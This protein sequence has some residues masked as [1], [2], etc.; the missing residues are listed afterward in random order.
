MQN[1]LMMLCSLE[2][3]A[4]EVIL[5]Q[6]CPEAEEDF[7]YHWRKMTGKD[8]VLKVEKHP[9]TVTKKTFFQE[10]FRL[11]SEKGKVYISGEGPAGISHGLYEVL[12]R[13]GCDWIVPGELGEVIPK[14]DKPDLGE[15]DFEQAPSFDY[16]NPWYPGSRRAVN[17]KY[18]ADYNL[19]KQRHKLSRPG[20]VHPLRN[21]G[22]H[23]WQEFIRAYQKEFDENPEMYALVRQLD[24]T[25]VRKGP[26]IETTSAK[27]LD[28]YEKHIREMFRKNNWPADK[29]VGIGVG[30][31]DGGGAS[32]S[33]ETVSAASGQLNPLS[34]SPELIDIMILFCNQLLA[35]LEKDYPNLHLGFYLYS[36]HADYPVR[37]PIHPKIVIV[38][39]DI[40]Y[41][42]MHSSQEKVPS[43]IYYRKIMEKWANTPNIKF[44]RGYNWNLAEN[45][46]PYS[47][48]KIWE[49]DL[50]LYHR[51]GIRGV[52][53]ESNNGWGTLAPSNYF[54]AKMLWDVTLKAAPVLHR[55]CVSAF[56]KA[57]APMEKY[58][59]M[60]TDRQSKAKQE[61]GSFHSFG[62]IYDNAFLDEA[63]KLFDEA[64]S[65]A[66][67]EV[68]RRRIDMFYIPVRQLRLF[69][70]LRAKMHAFRFDE[71]EKLFFRIQQERKDMMQQIPYSVSAAAISY[72][73]RFFKNPVTTSAK[74]SRA[75]YK[76]EFKVP[77]RLPFAFDP[78]NRGEDLGFADPEVDDSG[79][80]TMRTYSST[81]AAQG[82]I[83]LSGSTWYRVRVPRIEGNAGLLIGGADKQV[84]VY[85]NGKFI[86]EDVGFSKAMLFDLTGHLDGE[87]NLL[88]IQVRRRG[89]SELGTGGLIY[90]CYI[91][92]GPRLT[93]EDTTPGEQYR[94]LPGGAVE[95]VRK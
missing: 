94:L 79:W 89:S 3:G 68:Q 57:A 87:N 90:P 50:P 83:G 59:L 73:D 58:Y 77:D 43:R 64:R 9:Y 52:D 13:L 47:K 2:L 12:Q 29:L 14:V 95:K 75:P 5:D 70:E 69:L 37:Y 19:W 53:N 20:A 46:L 91:F 86:G 22:G 60:L 74:Y 45:I 93:R 51:M 40:G 15:L 92:T 72:F 39:A 78:T 56:G 76:I 82:L 42:R 62:L 4:F 23:K 33:P 61:A 48:L 67:T 18:T 71:A 80:L 38:I 35:R 63:D 7:Q 36:W 30:P 81:W 31:A 25:P 11:K 17:A 88:A 32:Q 54:E 44:F 8:A 49:D 6:H 55:F 34:G 84:K 24:G 65:L 10:A 27:L 16:R 28:L 26:Q 41:S 85:C 21:C 1:L 66:E